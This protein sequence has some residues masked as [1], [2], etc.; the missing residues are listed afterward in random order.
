[1]NQLLYI[2]SINPMKTERHHFDII[3]SPLH[4]LPFLCNEEMYALR[5]SLG[6]AIETD[7]CADSFSF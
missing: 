1:M 6:L 3:Q 4:P 7:A 5:I 2:R